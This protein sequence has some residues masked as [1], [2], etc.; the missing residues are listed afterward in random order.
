MTEPQSR[1]TGLQCARCGTGADPDRLQ[2]VCA[3]GGTLAARYD[4][5]AAR[6]TLTREALGARRRGLWRW[7][8]IL[9]VRD[10][11]RRRGLGE[12]DTP[13]FETPRLGRRI[14]IPGLRVKDEGR[15]PGGSFKA[16]G[17]AVAVARAGELGATRFALPSAG[18]AGGAA[19]AYGAR[20]GAEVHVAMPRETPAPFRRETALHGA[21]T[22]AVD[23]DIAEA[24]RWL[25][26][27][28]AAAGCFFLST[29]KEPYR[30]EGKKTMG[31][32]LVEQCGGRWPDV[33]IYPTGGGTG[34][35]GMAKAHDEMRELGLVTGPLPRFV[36]VQ[37]AGCAPLVRAFERGEARAEPWADPRT[38]ASGLRVPGTIGDH[39]ILDVLAR[40]H[41]AAV[42]VTDAE[43]LAA[44]D[45]LGHREG[46]LA[47]PE[48]AATAAAAR[49]LRES[50]WIA[51]DDDVVLF[52]SG[53]GFKYPDRAA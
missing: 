12:G 49:R 39:I 36:V 20:W 21:R 3:C 48:A 23:G 31:L 45:D 38:V 53:N 13:L 11:A 34:I 51:E 42:A 15:N 25:A 32:E 24:G 30:V 40:S 19:A 17:M 28:P 7:A 10:P 50:G 9:P 27:L 29:L 35:V 41:G 14:G 2:T 33:V 6:R 46:I 8:E 16:R 52:L 43:I 18:N 1:L 37:A 5:A 4:L 44:R 26:G 22:Y 47:A